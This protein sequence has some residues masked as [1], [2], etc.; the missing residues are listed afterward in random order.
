MFGFAC[1]ENDDLMPMPI[2]LAHRFA[3]RLSEVRKAGV[4]PY[5][6]P[7]GKVQVTIGYEDGKAR[8]AGHGRDLDASTSP[9]STSRR[10]SSRT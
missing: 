6:R 10:F 1:S 4:L 7:D 9:T 2:W 8:H 5:L 3:Q